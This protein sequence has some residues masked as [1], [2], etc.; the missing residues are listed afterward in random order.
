MI[1]RVVWKIWKAFTSD[2]LP[3]RKTNSLQFRVLFATDTFLSQVMTGM[4]A[5]DEHQTVTPN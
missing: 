5:I 3:K 4:F 2:F 1:E